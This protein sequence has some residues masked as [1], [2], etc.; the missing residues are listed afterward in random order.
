MYKN[1]TTFTM[2]FPLYIYMY[3]QVASTCTCTCVTR[4]RTF[5]VR[6]IGNN[7]EVVGR[8][9]L[10]SNIEVGFGQQPDSITNTLVLQSD[11]IHRHQLVSHMQCSTSVCVCVCVCVCVR[12]ASC[13]K[14]K[15]D[16]D[17]DVA[18]VIKGPLITVTHSSH[19]SYSHIHSKYQPS[20]QRK[21]CDL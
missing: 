14:C 11:S 12:Q 7:G 3:V 9:Y 5:N 20:T 10:Q 1:M 2:T 17:P 13:D 6:E 15:S 21:K 8:D 4:Q 16:V 19:S 18:V